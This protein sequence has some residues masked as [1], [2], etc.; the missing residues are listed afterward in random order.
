MYVTSH[1]M[2][3]QHGSGAVIVASRKSETVIESRNTGIKTWLFGR[4]R[5]A[6]SGKRGAES[7]GRRWCQGLS[8]EKEQSS[9]TADCSPSS[10][11]K[12]GQPLRDTRVEHGRVAP[13]AQQT[14]STPEEQMTMS[15]QQLNVQLSAISRDAGNDSPSSEK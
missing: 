15:I 4:E 3:S 10:E 11:S 13:R 12:R 9:R 2:H 5:R 8:R 1:L 7:S 6:P 14:M